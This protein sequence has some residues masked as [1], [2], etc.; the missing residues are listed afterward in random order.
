[1]SSVW[2]RVVGTGVS[3]RCGARSPNER[4]KSR[5]GPFCLSLIENSS[6]TF[7]CVLKRSALTAARPWAGSAVDHCCTMSRYRIVCCGAKLQYLASVEQ[8]RVTGSSF[9]VPSTRFSVSSMKLRCGQV[10]MAP[11]VISGSHFPRTCD[12]WSIGVISYLLLCGYPPFG[13][14]STAEL[15]EQIQVCNAC[16]QHGNS[17]MNVARRGKII[18]RCAARVSLR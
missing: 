11:E 10:Y 16:V 2:R 9:L 17:I 14:S 7:F 6:L 13:G 3:V 4:L 8:P 5:F 18:P 12:M 15:K 1:M